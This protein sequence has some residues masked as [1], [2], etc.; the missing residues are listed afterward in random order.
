M[1]GKLIWIVKENEFGNLLTGK[2][3]SSRAA[4]LADYFIEQ[5]CAVLSWSSLWTH[6]TKTF[7]KDNRNIIELKKGLKLHVIPATKGYIKNISIAR[8][9]QERQIAKHFKKAIWGEKEKPDLIYCCWPL[10][11]TSY[12][13]VRYGKKN[14]I[15]VVID[16]RD[17][18]PDIFIQPFPKFLKPFAQIG[19]NL[20]FRRQACIALQGATMV[21]GTT[22]K[23]FD[24]PPKY[25]RKRT[26][27]DHFVYHCYRKPS[28]SSE[29]LAAA[30][31][32]WKADGID[33]SSINV[34]YLGSIGTRIGDF[35]TIFQ[36]AE[37]LEK[38]NVKFIICG[39]GIDYDQ[40]ADKASKHSNVV[41]AGLCNQLELVSLASISNVGLIPYRNT[42]DFVDSLPTKFSEY[43]SCSL[44]IFTSLSG[45]SKTFVEENGCGRYYSD[46]NSLVEELRKLINN[47]ELEIR[48]H[49]A[50]HALYEKMFNA[51]VVYK[52]FVKELI[53]LSEGEKNK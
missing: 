32:E 25:G 41:M 48:M 31:N 4:M 45:L 28:F 20:L 29:Q 2:A 5:G 47:R 13:A 3:R 11:E 12:E 21:T 42:F 49:E 51:D 7:V 36:A 18:W 8:I 38:E 9:A 27:V 22:P 50:S 10:I 6:S 53:S 44:I 40:V 46:A 34:V 30:K 24:L 1:T 15:P 26:Q 39:T 14:N 43:L 35:D 33:D 17:M 37:L 52:N 16:I 23:A 19:I